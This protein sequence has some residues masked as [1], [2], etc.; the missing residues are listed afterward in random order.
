MEFLT[1][2]IVCDKIKSTFVLAKKIRK[3]LLLLMNRRSESVLAAHY[4][5]GGQPAAGEGGGMLITWI[6]LPKTYLTV[7]AH[8]KYI[9][10]VV[11]GCALATTTTRV[12]L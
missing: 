2:S 1:C 10:A 7:Y 6:R 12:L 4:A 5:S 8:T 11:H 9:P 3:V